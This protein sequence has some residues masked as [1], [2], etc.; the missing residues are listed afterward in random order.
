MAGF[1]DVIDVPAVDG[2]GPLLAGMRAEIAKWGAF[3]T[4]RE[5][6]DREGGRTAAADEEAQALQFLTNFLTPRVEQ[7]AKAGGDEQFRMLQLM[8]PFDTPGAMQDY[9]LHFFQMAP[10]VL[11]GALVFEER[12]HFERDVFLLYDLFRVKKTIE[13]AEALEA[14]RKS[15]A[16]TFPSMLDEAR[17]GQT[18]ASLKEVLGLL[19][20]Q[21]L[22]EELVKTLVPKLSTDLLSGAAVLER[23]EKKLLYTFPQILSAYKYRNFFFMLFFREGFRA[24]LGG[25]DKEFRYNYARFQLLRHEF[26][27]HWLTVK[28]K[29][30]P[31]KYE[32][33]R[34]Y[35]VKGK[36]L[37]A[38]L[39][40]APEREAEILKTI[41]ARYFNDITSRINEKLPPDLA[42]GPIPQSEAFGFYY[43]LK[44]QLTQAVTYVRAP[45]EE[46]RAFVKDKKPLTPPPPP[47]PAPGTAATP[48]AAA[49]AKSYGRIVPSNAPKSN[50][51]V[52]TLNVDSIPDPFFKAPPGGG[53]KNQLA[54][55]KTKLG[56]DY[57]PFHEFVSQV[58]EHTPDAEKL[59]RFAPR[60]EWAVPFLMR[61][62]LHN[63]SREYL[64]ILGAEVSAK[65]KGMKLSAKEEH[66][67]EPYFIF[68]AQKDPEG[69]FGATTGERSA[70]N[71]AFQEY[72]FTTTGVVTIVQEMLG[73]LRGMWTVPGAKA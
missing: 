59:M 65:P 40:E 70:N 12:D 45:I 5:K 67:F 24:K 41:P 51:G 30:D 14:A 64:L 21:C 50:W 15:P 16:T 48:A 10:T 35:Q 57:G 39:A 53:F 22:P 3:W 62:T 42:A 66:N 37:L 69:D 13:I 25:Q 55:L 20:G 19:Y 11:E 9:L 18:L 54:I 47:R 7:L 1:E 60:H 56:K 4:T 61:R 73:V 63:A 68:A 38:W 49:G 8:V 17:I 71:Q 29:N 23:R 31:R 26:L 52:A 58:L 27:V 43:D 34:R 44:R 28:L 72:G 32:V 46:L 36:A 33:Y 2:P 6:E